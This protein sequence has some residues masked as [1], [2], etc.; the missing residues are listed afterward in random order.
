MPTMSSKGKERVQSPDQLPWGAIFIPITGQYILKN[1]EEVSWNH[2][3]KKWWNH[4]DAD[5][6]KSQY[7]LGLHST[8]LPPVVTLPEEPT[9]GST[10]QSLFRLEAPLPPTRELPESP[11]HLEVPKELQGDYPKETPEQHSQ[12][13]PKETPDSEPE[14]EPRTPEPTPKPIPK[15]LPKPEP[16]PMAESS[17]DAINNACQPKI[18]LGKIKKFSGSAEE[19]DEFLSLMLAIF[20]VNGHIYDNDQK[21]IIY[22]L[23]NMEEGIAG[24]QRQMKLL[25]FLNPETGFPTWAE[26]Q[27]TLWSIFMASDARNMAWLKIEH[28]KQEKDEMVA[29]YNA[30]FRI[31]AVKT[32]IM[33]Q[34]V[35]ISFYSW[36]LNQDVLLIMMSMENLPMTYE[37]Y[38]TCA[39]QIDMWQHQ[40]LSMATGRLPAEEKKQ[41][42]S[43]NGLTA[44]IR[45]LST[46]E[47]KRCQDENLCFH[48]GKYRH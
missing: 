16:K 3:H 34:S 22:V 28:I 15:P 43:V 23:T 13:L 10:F 1:R 4:T 40:F 46:K 31:L 18:K 24:P 38:L 42:I 36:R 7:F 25:K 26:F 17:K 48:C 39:E 44:T 35:L 12:D 21:K 37:G 47:Q 9:I 20:K 30:H 27:K 6:V 19:L 29:E 41:E 45:Q 11:T 2:T 33:D 8:P 32:G 5:W 14:P